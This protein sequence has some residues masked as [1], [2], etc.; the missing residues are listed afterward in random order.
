VIERA[1]HKSEGSTQ[2][3]KFNP[4]ILAE[5]FFTGLTVDQNMINMVQHF[6]SSKE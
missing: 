4:F 1:S 3:S 2:A 5:E 6:A